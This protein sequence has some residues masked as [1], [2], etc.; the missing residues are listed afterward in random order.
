MDTTFKS[1][2]RMRGGK[3]GSFAIK[4]KPNLQGSILAALALCT[5]L[6]AQPA[7]AMN[8]PKIPFA[9]KV[10]A[11]DIVFEGRLLSFGKSWISLKTA[12]GKSFFPLQDYEVQKVWKGRFSKKRIQVLYPMPSKEITSMPPIDR[13]DHPAQSLIMVNALVLENGKSVYVTD[14]CQSSGV[15]A[16]EEL[17]ILN[18]KFPAADT[19]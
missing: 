17:K 4:Q 9:E 18:Q 11:A 10:D 2:P 8:C 15:P 14:M 5:L 12:D 7:Q 16:P 3:G 1:P 19:Q 6:F 13:L